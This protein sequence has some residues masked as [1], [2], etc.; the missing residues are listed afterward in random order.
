MKASRA[1][2][3][4]GCA[5]FAEPSFAQSLDARIAAAPDGI[6][7]MSYPAREG[8]CGS[9]QEYW[10]RDRADHDWTSG[11]DGGPARVQLTKRG[12]LIVTLRTYVGGRWQ[13]RA[14]V[15][16]LGDVDAVAARD[17]LLDLVARAAPAVAEDALLPAVI[18]D[19]P[20]PWQRLLGFAR[21]ESLAQDVREQA[22]FWLGQSAAREATAGLAA[23]VDDDG[24]TEVQKAAV[25]ALSQ[26]E[27]SA[28]IEELV[29]VARRHR[30]PEVVKSALFWLADSE[31]PRAVDLF[32]ELLAR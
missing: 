20:D 24:T 1:I 32:E 2:A 18:A 29:R 14:D 13:P 15:T 23:I 11:C 3:L 7:R 28:R 19:A 4:L 17:F 26:G 12:T 5:A 25:F 9:G 8:T 30:N 27:G 16:D 6:V 22:I 31:D 10:M 21:D